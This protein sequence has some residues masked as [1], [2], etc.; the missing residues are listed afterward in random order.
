MKKDKVTIW[1]E[2]VRIATVLFVIGFIAYLMYDNAQT[3]ARLCDVM[4]RQ[5]EFSGET[6]DRL[7]HFK[8]EGSPSKRFLELYDKKIKNLPGWSYGDQREDR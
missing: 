2:I 8:N 5:T 1:I 6:V 7:Y 4:E 3:D